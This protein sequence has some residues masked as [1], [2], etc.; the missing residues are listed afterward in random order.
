MLMYIHP[1]RVIVCFANRGDYPEK[2]LNV[3]HV[4]HICALHMCIN[5]RITCVLEQALA[6][7]SAQASCHFI[8][9]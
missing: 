9:L 7:L 3:A 1:R 6:V 8:Q 2:S 5:T 4:C